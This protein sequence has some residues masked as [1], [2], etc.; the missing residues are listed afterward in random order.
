MFWL[1][2]QLQKKK[3]FKQIA[4]TFP[5]TD[6]GSGTQASKSAEN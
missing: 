4:P 1:I 6:A 5:L 2:Y 3:K